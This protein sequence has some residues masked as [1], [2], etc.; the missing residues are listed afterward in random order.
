VCECRFS[1]ILNPAFSLV[2]LLRSDGRLLRSW[3]WFMNTV[4]VSYV[5]TEHLHSSKNA[6]S[7][8]I[9]LQFCFVL[10]HIVYFPCDTI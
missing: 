3:S 7:I 5:N 1:A 8:V 2:K 10:I 6:R 9:F 4:L